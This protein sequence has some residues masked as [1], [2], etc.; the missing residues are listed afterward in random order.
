MAWK[1][2]HLRDKAVEMRTKQHM[3]LDEICE[4]L[5]LPKGTVDD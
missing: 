1:H 3:T 4:R 2:A 5:S